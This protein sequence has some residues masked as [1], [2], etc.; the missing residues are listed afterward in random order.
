MLIRPALT[1]VACSLAL[2]AAALTVPAASAADDTSWSTPTALLP[3][4]ASSEVID[5][6]RSDDRAAALVS[7]PFGLFILTA[8][9]ASTDSGWRLIEMLSP[10]TLGG[11]VDEVEPAIAI[12]GD[13]TTVAWCTKSGTDRTVSVWSTAF[14]QRTQE[15]YTGPS[16]TSCRGGVDVD[17]AVANSAAS[18]TVAW[19]G[20]QILAES[21]L[22]RTWTVGQ[23]QAP[24]IVWAESAGN[25]GTPSA[26]AVRMASSG[27]AA[28]GFLVTDRAGNREATLRTAMRGPGPVTADWSASAAIDAAWPVAGSAWDIDL[29]PASPS[30]YAVAWQSDAGILPTVQYSRQSLAARSELARGQA[31]ARGTAEQSGVQIAATGPGDVVTWAEQDGDEYMVRSMIWRL[32]DADVTTTTVSSGRAWEVQLDLYGAREGSMALAIGRTLTQAAGTDMQVLQDT[33]TTSA[34][35]WQDP[36]VGTVEAATPSATAASPAVF[37]PNS[38]TDESRTRLIWTQL[39]NS[40]GVITPQA[41]GSAEFTPTTTPKRPSKVTVKAKPGKKILVKWTASRSA[42][43]A[44]YVVATKKGGGAYRDRA[45]G[46]VLKKTFK[47][48]AGTKYCYKV[49]TIDSLGQ[50]SSWTKAKCARGKR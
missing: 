25:T 2:T 3:S 37:V 23:W 39:T 43:V 30:A 6:A 12:A 38:I 13:H 14:V 16:T 27:A 18:F 50:Q 24:Q 11:S 29:Q 7:S 8:P 5:I 1:T 47:V 44:G 19:S 15:I 42:D 41:L 9:A 40:G 33:F 31:V 17:G 49:A 28:L 10:A 26:P 20:G 48:K 22:S 34:A 46:D 45:V 35:L 36:V 21:M 32:G 4:A